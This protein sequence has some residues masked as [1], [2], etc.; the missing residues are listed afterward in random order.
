M[1]TTISRFPRRSARRFRLSVDI[2]D[3]KVLI[4]AINRAALPV[5]QYPF[6]IGDELVSVDGRPV[7][8]LI[9]SFRKYAIAANQRS[10]DRTAAARIV[11]RSQQIMP[12]VPELGDTA[13]L[14]IRLASTGAR[15]PTRFPGARSAYPSRRK[16]RCRAPSASSSVRPDGESC[17]QRDR[18]GSRGCSAPIHVPGRRHTPPPTTRCRL[19]CGRSRR[20]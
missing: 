12:H 3:G 17:R 20:C 13:T 1:R 11:S 5:A 7:Q 9:Q 10:T 6:A 8:E 4:D 16:G 14:V 15:T 18:N 19:T 2:Y